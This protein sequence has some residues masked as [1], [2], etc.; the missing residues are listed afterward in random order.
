VRYINYMNRKI[1]FQQMFSTKF[2]FF[3]TFYDLIYFRW[4]NALHHLIPSYIF[5]T[6]INFP[7][8]TFLFHSSTDC[9]SYW[10]N[11]ITS[12]SHLRELYLALRTS[13]Y[14]SC[15]CDVFDIA[16]R[17]CD[18]GK[19][20]RTEQLRKLYRGCLEGNGSEIERPPLNSL[21]GTRQTFGH[22]LFS[23]CY[24]VKCISDLKSTQK[25]SNS[26]YTDRYPDT[27]LL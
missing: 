12:P 5:C 24:C 7:R 20:R 16:W 8:A 21:L 11:G 1:L 4:L 3:V 18:S 9:D 13:L 19:K 23:V 6:S 25:D 22:L 17:H 15:A 14:G 10:K 26:E 2:L 27:C